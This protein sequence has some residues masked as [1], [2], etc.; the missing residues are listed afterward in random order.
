MT[1]ISCLPFFFFVCL[2]NWFHTVLR[3]LS[4]CHTGLGH[5]TANLGLA[6]EAVPLAAL[7]S[8]LYPF[9]VVKVNALLFVLWNNILGNI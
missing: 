6:L 3:P 4:L 1:L 2:L 5:S 7:T 9:S 8:V